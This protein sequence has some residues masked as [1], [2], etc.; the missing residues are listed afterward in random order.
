[1][2]LGELFAGYGGLGMGV[3]LALGQLERVWVSEFDPAPSRVLSHH[4]PGVP[5]LGDIT[6]VDWSQVESVDILTGGFPCQDVSLAGARKGMGEGTR[7]GLWSEMARAI[8]ALRPRLVVIENVRGLLSATAGKAHDADL[9]YCPICMGDGSGDDLRAFGAVLGDLAELGFDAEWGMLKAS[10]VGA[11]HGRARVFIVA[12]PAVLDPGHDAGGTERAQQPADATGIVAETGRASVPAG[13]ML[14]TPTAQYSGNT[15]QN[16]LRK[17]PG[18][19]QVTDLRI[20]V[21]EV[22]LLPTPRASR[23]ASA[24]ETVEMLPTPKAG[25]AEFGTPLTS[26]RPPEKSTH[27]AGRLRHTAFGD[28]APAVERWERV[29][30]RKAPEPLAT[31]VKGGKQLNAAFVEWLMGLPQ[32]HVTDP[33]IGL[34]RVQQLKALGNG[35]VP[36]QAATA[37]AE[38]IGRSA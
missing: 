25:D 7:S 12:W 15:A 37:V 35:V 11:P 9:E 10:D 32:G 38:L 20:L 14:P 3:E 16:H 6:Q 8:E 22:G 21:E 33:E 2:K 31:G 24:T 1:M 17:K 4:W 34:S 13:L 28:Y 30:G 19:T 23:G 27:L 36:Q 29:L 18:R 5:N 26:G